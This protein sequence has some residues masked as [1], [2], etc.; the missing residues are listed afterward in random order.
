MSRCENVL[1]YILHAVNVVVFWVMIPTFRRTTLPPSLR[2]EDEGSKTIRNDGI[3]PYHYTTS[4][5]RRPR[6][7]NDC[8]HRL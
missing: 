3:L 1:S 4:Q 5:P 8:F 6:L 7:V 2:P